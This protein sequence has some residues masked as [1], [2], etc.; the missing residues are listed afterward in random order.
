MEIHSLALVIFAQCQLKAVAS[1][2]T[3]KSAIDI[4][5]NEE[6][7]ILKASSGGSLPRSRQ[8]VKDMR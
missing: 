3:P 5:Y 2:K 6:G 7:G 8:Q 1:E 4:T